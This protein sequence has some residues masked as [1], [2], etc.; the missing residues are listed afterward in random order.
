MTMSTATQTPARTLFSPAR[1]AV[2]TFFAVLWI[3]FAG[4]W[5]GWGQFNQVDEY[6]V[7]SPRPSWNWNFPA[8]LDAYIHDHFG[9]RGWLITLNG[10]LR[11]RLLHTST[12]AKVVLGKQ[13]FMFY[14]G[15]QSMENYT[16]PNT[17]SDCELESWILIL[18]RRQAWLA[19]QGIP[20]FIVL[21]PDKQTIYP[22][23]M[24]DGVHHASRSSADRWVD[25]IRARTN[26]P[27]IDLRPGLM[28]EKQ[29]QHVY[30]LTDSHWNP[31]GSY[32][33][34]R[35]TLTGIAQ[36]APQLG[37]R[38]GKPVDAASLSTRP[39][40]IKGDLD[41]LLGLGVFAREKSQMLL[42]ASEAPFTA[43]DELL[44][45]GT[46]NPAQPRIVLL[47]DSFASAMAA[48]LAPHFSRIY[49]TT[50]QSLDPA[51]IAREHPDLVVVEMVERRLNEAPPVDPDNALNVQDKNAPY[52]RVWGLID[53]P[54]NAENLSG[55]QVRMGG[56]VLANQPNS[57]QKVQLLMDGKPVADM[58]IHQPHSGVAEAQPGMKD[59][60]RAGVEWFWNS[61]S[62]PNGLHRMLWR[63]TDTDGHTV[64]VG[65]RQF[66]V[67]N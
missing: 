1:L 32:V 58:N 20:L 37:E 53:Q 47:R 39:A 33:A 17:M 44:V 57:I 16:G 67:A 34:Y 30:H 24:A 8:S 35:E 59:S 25:A 50:G 13:G 63:A 54:F 46:S 31:W 28:R 6:R 61:R 11:A 49:G 26:I 22:E 43:N 12:S 29:H 40:S 48:F 23:M 2:G 27:L 19:S 15:N 3:L 36:A 42:P 14:A 10:L 9:F 55:E 4:T 7:V 60:A 56:W 51:L 38:I 41:R 21:A 52:P 64:D 62:L 65:T 18:E 66:C 45:G 5:L